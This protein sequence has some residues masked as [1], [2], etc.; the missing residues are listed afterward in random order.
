MTERSLDANGRWRNKPVT[1]RVSP[2]ECDRID[3]QVAMSGLSKQDYIAKRLMEEDVV[4]IPSSRVQ[5]ALQRQAVDIYHELRRIRSG[6]DISPE[7]QARIRVFARTFEALGTDYS[8]VSAVEIED[9]LIA[10]M[11]RKAEPAGKECD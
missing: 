3:A 8:G 5:R 9:G 10:N 1:F 4:V 6:G 7:L 2:E 11:K